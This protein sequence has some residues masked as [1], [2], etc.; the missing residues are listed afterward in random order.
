MIAKSWSLWY[1]DMR[2]GIP[3]KL[4]PL[5]GEAVPPATVDLPSGG[6]NVRHEP[7]GAKEWLG[8]SW[9]AWREE[10]PAWFTPTWQVRFQW[11]NP[12]FLLKNPDFLIRNPGFLLKNVDFIIK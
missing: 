3:C 12:E 5:P 6:G 7:G 9:T 11:K 10:P 8:N 1:D 2:A 4:W